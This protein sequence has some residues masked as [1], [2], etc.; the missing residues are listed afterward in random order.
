MRPCL[1]I[2]PG[3]SS[4]LCRQSLTSMAPRTVSWTCRPRIIA[5]EVAE[6]VNCSR[7]SGDGLL[8]GV[9]EVS[10]FFPVNWNGPMPRMPFSDWNSTSCPWVYG[11]IQGWGCL[12]LGLRT[13]LLEPLARFSSLFRFYQ[14]LRTVL[15]SILYFFLGRYAERKSLVYDVSWVKL[16]H[17]N[18]FFNFCD[19]DFP[20]IAIMGLKF[21]AVA[22]KIKL[23]AVSPFHALTKA[24]SEEVLIQNVWFAV[25][26]LTSLPRH[27]RAITC[28]SEKCWNASTACIFFSKR[29]LRNK[30]YL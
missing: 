16:A 17:W 18:K 1:T 3:F 14:A 27:L 9:D 10:V 29:S 28:W 21:L 25:K 5:N 26:I 4:L 23:P 30:I 24:K 7:H 12:C 13:N 19:S 2:L 6:S 20:A 11:L 22:L 8:A 15:C